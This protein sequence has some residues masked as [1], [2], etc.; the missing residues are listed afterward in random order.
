MITETRV[1][2]AVKVK[3]LG[4]LLELMKRV[5]WTEQQTKKTLYDQTSWQFSYRPGSSQM[6]KTTAKEIIQGDCGTACCISGWV[7]VDQGFKRLGVEID[8]TD[9]SAAFYGR[10]HHE[11]FMD[12]FGITEDEAEDLIDGN[13]RTISKSISMINALYKA[14]KRDAKATLRADKKEIRAIEK[15][16]AA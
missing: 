7:A 16:L 2:I 13:D 9:G 10:Y 15:E 1:P 11:A 6:L 8:I 5:K 14:A 4:M 3:R 12:L